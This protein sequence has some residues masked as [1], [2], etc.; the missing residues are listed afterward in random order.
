MARVNPQLL[1]AADGKKIIRSNPMMTISQYFQ[2]L[3]YAQK[4]LNVQDF[5][6]QIANASDEQIE[7]WV[8]QFCYRNHLSQND[9]QE[10]KSAL[11]A[12]DLL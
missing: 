3:I 7:H 11:L 2:A 9:Y 5:Q 8:K 12:S 1:S 6:H 4:Q 10:I